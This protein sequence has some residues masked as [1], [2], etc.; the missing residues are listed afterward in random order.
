MTIKEQAEEIRDERLPGNNTAKK[1]GGV[2]VALAESNDK[3][4]DKDLLN[5]DTKVIQEKVGIY[6]SEY[7]NDT[8]ASRR[9]IALK[10]WDDADNNRSIGI[11]SEGEPFIT[12]LDPEENPERI[13]LPLQ[14]MQVIWKPV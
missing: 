6:E 11:T 1:V 5:I 2:L 14:K 7:T 3:K 13:L 12:M 10:V 4:A 8:D 9:F